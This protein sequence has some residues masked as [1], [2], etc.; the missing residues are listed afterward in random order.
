MT[1]V[2]APTAYTPTD[3]RPLASR[4]HP[5]AIRVSKA[6]AA[7]GASANAI[8]ILG[9][10]C[11]VLAGGCFAATGL[12]SLPGVAER[13]LWLAG[14]ALVQGRLICN[15]LDGMVA[16][17][18]GVASPVGELYNEVPDRVSD[19]ATFGGLGYA[20]ASSPALGLLAAGLAVLVAYVRAQARVAGAPQDYRGPM[21][22]QQRMALVTALGAFMALAPGA[23][24][25]APAGPDARW[26]V[27]AIV[28]AVICAGCVVT[29]VR[30]LARAAAVLRARPR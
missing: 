7:R 12:A 2:T 5:L 27:P 4:K 23:W 28:L 24:R 30:R 25:T 29:C 9:M 17:E 13:G 14:A 18:R 26:G 15:L 10:V 1:G 22:K 21:A 11:G 3:R 6:L 16:I 20:A 8:S 19:L